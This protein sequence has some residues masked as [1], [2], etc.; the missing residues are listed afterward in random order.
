MKRLSTI[1][2]RAVLRSVYRNLVP[3]LSNATRWS[4]TFDIVKCFVELQ[5]YVNSLCF[6]N[7]T[8][9]DLHESLLLSESHFFNAVELQLKL[10]GLQEVTLELLRTSQ[11]LVCQ[12][13]V[14]V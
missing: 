6:Q 10:Q 4:G 2:G 11:K 7:L 12:D 1:N 9:L 13:A 8:K 5:P 14:R 3:I